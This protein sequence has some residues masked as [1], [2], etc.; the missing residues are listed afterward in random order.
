MSLTYRVLCVPLKNVLVN[1]NF[2][3]LLEVTRQEHPSLEVHYGGVGGFT[4]KKPNKRPDPMKV[5]QVQL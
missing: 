1:E 5:I 2:V 4:A 3:Q